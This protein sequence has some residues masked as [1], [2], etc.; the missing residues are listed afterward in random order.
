[1]LRDAVAVAPTPVQ[2]GGIA[3]QAARA[4]GMLGHFD[5]AAMLCRQALEDAGR[6]PA[7]LRERLEAELIT[8]GLLDASTVPEARRCAAAQD[9]AASV[10]QLWRVTASCTALLDGAPAAGTLELLRPVLDGNL[11]AAELGSLLDTSTTCQLLL[12]D[13]LA[14]GLARCTALVELARPRGWLIA[15]AHGCMFRALGRV[16]AGEIRA[17]EVDARLAFDH[18]LA[19]AP[20][21]AVLWSLSFLLDALVEGGDL[22]GADDALSVAGQQGPPPGSGW[23]ALFLLQSR[24]RLRL[25]QHRPAE[26]LADASAARDRAAELGIRHPVLACWR[27]EAVEALVALGRGPE[28]RQPARDAVRLAEQLGTA[29]ARGAALRVLARTEPHP[30]PV[31]ERAVAVLSGS[32]AGLEHTRALVDLGAALRRAN[33]RADARSALRAALDRAERGGMALLARR[34]REELLAAGA[35][36]RRSAVSGPGALT[37]AEHRIAVLAAQGQS[38]RAI[39]ERLYVTQ[40]TVETHLT[41]AFAKL[42][43]ATRADLG[44]AMGGDAGRNAEAVAG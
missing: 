29:G 11:L 31:L 32:P 36:P 41:H 34:A 6:Y 4:L 26:A 18:K 8:V 5:R 19:V 17:A 7:E 40:R 16:R 21:A 23:G 15:L 1:M 28:A 2:R 27:G 33:R 9:G 30:I 25:A 42:Q 20:A 44:P 24:A 43:I 10:L 37:P 12:D 38:N 22:E 14:A 3:L 39:A 35:R 13:E